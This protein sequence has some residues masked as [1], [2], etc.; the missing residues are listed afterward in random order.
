[1]AQLTL[2]IQINQGDA[3]P[4]IYHVHSIGYSYQFG[5]IKISASTFVPQFLFTSQNKFEKIT[6]HLAQL[7]YLF[8]ESFNSLFVSLLFG[9]SSID[10]KLSAPEKRAEIFYDLVPSL[11]FIWQPSD[12]DRFFI[13]STA[14]ID[15]RIEKTNS[16]KYFGARFNYSISIGYTIYE[17][18]AN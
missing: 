17:E 18:S 13:A 14:G 11:G 2:T 7:G 9:V 5:R 4:L 8:D 12:N 6:G 15:F 16:K 10:K 1:M 3:L